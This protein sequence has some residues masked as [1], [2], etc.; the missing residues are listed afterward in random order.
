MPEDKP[1][2][3]FLVVLDT[4]HA[5]KSIRI[6]KKFVVACNIIGALRAAGHLPYPTHTEQQDGGE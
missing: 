3:P 5:T 2:T 6:D 1:T 4:L